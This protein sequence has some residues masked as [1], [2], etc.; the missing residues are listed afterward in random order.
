VG[1]IE[2]IPD[3]QEPE[4]YFSLSHIESKEWVI[5]HLRE[6]SSRDEE[7]IRRSFDEEILKAKGWAGIMKFH[8][9]TEPG[10]LRLRYQEGIPEDP[11][12]RCPV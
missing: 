12:G 9:R 7:T 6:H 4:V 8:L 1:K 11:P 10:T 3:P 2:C 5:R